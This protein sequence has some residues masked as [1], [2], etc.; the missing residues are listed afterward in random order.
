MSFQFSHD[1]TFEAAFRRLIKEQITKAHKHLALRDDPARSVHEPRKCMK[2][3]RALMRLYRPALGK[4][5]YASENARYRDMGRLLSASRDRQVMAETVSALIDDFKKNHKPGKSKS[6]R[7]GLA[8]LSDILDQETGKIQSKIDDVRGQQALRRRLILMLDEAQQELGL[9]RLD[10][11]GFSIVGRG[12][13]RS[14]QRGLRAFLRVRKSNDDD[15]LH[16]WR[17]SVQVH[18]RH[19]A[20]F[21]Q[22]WPDFFAFRIRASKQLSMIL[23]DHQDLCLVSDFMRSLPPH[24]LHPKQAKALLKD[25]K[26][27]K[28][29]LRDKALLGGALLFADDPK[30]LSL[31][32]EKYWMI[33]RQDPRQIGPKTSKT[34]RH[35]KRLPLRDKKDPFK[36]A[37][38]L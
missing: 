25:I 27:R 18:W 11:H 30:V 17:K 6:L 29:V 16:D 12:L 26:K 15:V 21:Q 28:Q 1:E 13:E 3:L 31:Q 19:M 20:L 34:N 7:D 9:L 23:G 37:G 2:R 10:G 4:S 22:A 5:D 14:T 8:A 32:I 38:D 24:L 35:S 36:L 33:W